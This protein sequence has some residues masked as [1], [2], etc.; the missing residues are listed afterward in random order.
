MRIF[1]RAAAGESV[2]RAEVV[3]RHKRGAK[4]VLEGSFNGKIVGGKAVTIRGILS[5][6]TERKQAEEAR[7]ENE[8]KFRFLFVGNPLPMWVQDTKTLKFIEVNNAAVNHYGYTREEFLAMPITEMRPPED[9][10]ALLDAI[11][12]S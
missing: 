1:E 8:A 2:G 4:L 7:R 11:Q 9:V 6:I 5:D 12:T 3:F 10:P